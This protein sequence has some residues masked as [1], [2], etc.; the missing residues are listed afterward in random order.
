MRVRD[1]LYRLA[2]RLLQLVAELVATYE[3]AVSRLGA[4]AEHSHDLS[5]RHIKN[6]KYVAVLGA[7]EQVIFHQEIACLMDCVHAWDAEDYKHD[8][9]EIAERPSDS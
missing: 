7:V 6:E 2:Q 5:Y 4:L 3:V 8:Q 1:F 9:R